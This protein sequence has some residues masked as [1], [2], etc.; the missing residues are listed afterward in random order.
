MR[1]RAGSFWK[2]FGNYVRRPKA[3][4]SRRLEFEI[5]EDRTVPSANASGVVSGVVF[6]DANANGTFDTG[7]PTLPGV[8]VSLSGSTSQGTPISVS[9]A[10]DVNG[11]FSINV[12]PGTYQLSAGPIPALTGGTASIGGISA[13]TGV[14]IVS[15][16]PVAGGQAVSQNLGFSGGLDPHF[17]SMTQFLTSTTGADFPYGTPGTGTAPTVSTPISPIS[18]PVGTPSTLIDLAGH[19]TDPDITDTLVTFNT[20]DG[21]MHLELFDTQAPQTVANFLDYVRSGAYNNLVFTRNESTFV[22]Q[23]GALTLNS[24]GTNLDLVPTLPAVA[25]EF[26]NSNTEGTLAMA[27]APGDPNSATNQFFVNLVNN[28]ASL[29]SKKFTVFGKIADSGSQ[30][31][32]DALKAT[33]TVDL[34]KQPI[35]KTFPTVDFMNFPL[36][37]YTGTGANF[38]SDATTSNYLLIHNVTIDQ[39]SETLTYSVVSNSNPGL[40][41]ASI[42]DERLTLTYTAAQVGNAT[43]V[44]QATDRFGAT[45]QQSFTVT[46]TPKP[47]VI[48]TVNI[49]PDNAANAKE[50]IL[51]APPR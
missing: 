6:L 39:Q 18:V 38:P 19:F 25:N 2:D 27:Q 47:P 24:S 33:P 41:S 17:I 7:D 34:S 36:N 37:N 14:D 11:S 49:T 13:P 23:G 44:V 48:S 3:V 5:L 26:L 43:I 1:W 40:V 10:T 12:L 50:S 29:D 30:A 22:L 46:V 28:S 35:A 4:K 15:P 31:V 45:V 9:T 16:I 8:N 20:S 42:T 51:S 32:L 21:P